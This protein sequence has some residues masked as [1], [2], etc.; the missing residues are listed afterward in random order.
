MKG[1]DS[2]MSKKGIAIAVASGVAAGIGI[3][4]AVAAI[5]ERNVGASA[6]GYNGVPDQDDDEDEFGDSF[7]D[8][9][10]SE[11]DEESSAD[12]CAE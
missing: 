9:E 2:Q 7:E 4:A 1:V 11:D 10:D 8:E 5:K 6:E 12:A 3:I